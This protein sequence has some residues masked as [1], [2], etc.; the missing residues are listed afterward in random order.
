M[1]QPNRTL[2]PFAPLAAAMGLSENQAIIR[3]GVNGRMGQQ[4]R[5]EGMSERVADRL[6]VKAK[7]HPFE[8]WPEMADRAIRDVSDLD[9]IES[10]ERLE[11]RR[12]IA[13]E[14]ARRRYW[15]DEA[16]R[17]RKKAAVRASGAS[18]SRSR[19]FQPSQHGEVKRERD[20]AYYKRNREAILARK[21]AR[22]AAKRAAEA[23][24][25]SA[26][27]EFHPVEEAA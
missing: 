10:A 17:E 13:R 7:L 23:Q 3:L 19:R 6:A 5:H 14:S 11:R 27:V 4:Y 2:Y 12:R 18:R 1:T 24:A 21:H 26:T 15:E 25:P 8:V 16:L 9:K 20:R 22:D